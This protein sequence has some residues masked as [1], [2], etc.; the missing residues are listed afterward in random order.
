MGFSL[1]APLFLAGLAVVAVPIWVHLRARDRRDV[2]RFPS[3]RFFTRL[4]YRQA[5][6]QLL[7]HRFLFALRTLAL[8]L[9]VLAFTRPFY[10]GAPALALGG[11]GREVVIALDRSYSM[12]HAGTWERATSAAREAA[13]GAPP[14]SRLSL[15]SFAQEATIEAAPST[16]RQAVLDALERLAP[17]SGST[18]FAPALR[19]ADEILLDSTFAERQV[20]LVSDLQAAGWDRSTDTDAAVLSPGVELLTADVSSSRDTTANVSISSAGVRQTRDGSTMT[21]TARL[22][23]RGADA[24]AEVP[25]TVT[26]ET[27]EGEA[28]GRAEGSADLGPAESV[29][30]RLGPIDLEARPKSPIHRLRFSGRASGKDG[31]GQEAGPKAR[32]RGALPPGLA[33]ITVRLGDDSLPADNVFFATAAP[34]AAVPVLLIEAPDARPEASLYLRQ[35][36]A[37]APA[38]PDAAP[39]APQIPGLPSAR[40]SPAFDLRVRS[41]TETSPEDVAAAAVVVIHDSRFPGAATGRALAEHVAGGGG[42]W[43]VLGSRS[44]PPDGD[45]A[46]RPGGK[47]LERL[48]P[49][50]WRDSVDPAFAE[51]R[52]EGRGVGLS[53]IDYSHPVFEIF[54][55]PG[56][57]NLAAPRFY[58]YRPIDLDEANG[59]AAVA[60]TTDGAVALAERRLGKGRVLLWASPFDNRWSD[61]PVQ[62]V[63]LPFVH[64]VCRYL[65]GER[66]SPPWYRVG[67]ALDLRALVASI[68]V[69][70]AGTEGASTAI[71]ESPAG[72]QREISLDAV[73]S[74]DEAGFYQVMVPGREGTRL[75][76]AVNVDPA[77]SDLTKLD[78]EAFVA[79]STAEATGTVGGQGAKSLSRA[80]RERRQGIWWFLLLAALLVLAAESLWSNGQRISSRR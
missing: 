38:A 42:L 25:V 53:A 62:P 17:G 65:A 5:R 73:M 71:V 47:P 56:D 13:S 43:V 16:G 79:A 36:L 6:R 45:L 78:A 68:G 23:N 67:Q 52:L 60:R 77:E 35:A 54:A 37:V 69:E 75:P 1:L 49:G 9:L 41:A 57:G 55:G 15:V 32:F 22:V 28:G 51:R 29:S 24:I 4:P 66:T 58:R 12:A 59:A 70:D 40:P 74:L 46:S 33:R 39:D 76:V 50:T 21:V 10:D 31:L 80:Q 3:L 19:L 27:A 18:R 11:S 48:L 7:R 64:Q 14:G 2:L 44:R 61:L 26:V 30:L 34:R 63:F 72:N 20:V 8:I